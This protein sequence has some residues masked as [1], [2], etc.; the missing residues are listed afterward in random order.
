MSNVDE[1]KRELEFLIYNTT[2]MEAIERKTQELQEAR[3]DAE[4]LEEG[5]VEH[6]V[7]MEEEDLEGYEDR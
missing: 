6:M 5:R 7:H 1:L 4:V 2:D 3:E